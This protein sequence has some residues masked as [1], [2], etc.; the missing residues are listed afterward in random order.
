MIEGV[1]MIEWECEK[2]NHFA[3]SYSNLSHFMDTC[4]C[5]QTSVDL[6]EFY[7]RY[8]GYP[9]IIS[10]KRYNNNQWNEL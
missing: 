10:K 4:S 9:K 6:E 8:S 5:K 1:L 3:I 7:I 2:C